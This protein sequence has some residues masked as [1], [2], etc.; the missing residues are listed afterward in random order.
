MG[1]R[2]TYEMAARTYVMVVPATIVCILGMHASLEM[3]ME[4]V[5]IPRLHKIVAGATIADVVVTLLYILET[6]TEG[7]H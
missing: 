2:R 6:Y 7:A 3:H 4:D 5:C 1:H